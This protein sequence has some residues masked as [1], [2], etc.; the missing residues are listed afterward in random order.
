MSIE[1]STLVPTSEI[2]L[3]KA[4]VTSRIR[5]KA[6]EQGK[7]KTEKL[8]TFWVLSSGLKISP[9]LPL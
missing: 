6:E 1:Y 5:R 7:L 4:G 8:S 2:D 9:L 3:Q